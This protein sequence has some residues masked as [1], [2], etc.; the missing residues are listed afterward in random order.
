METLVVQRFKISMEYLGSKIETIGP[1]DGA[2]VGVDAHLG[3]VA[4]IVKLPNQ[5]VG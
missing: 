3:E 4:G 2:S 5:G 1:H